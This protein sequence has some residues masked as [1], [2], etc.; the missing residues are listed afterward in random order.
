MMG[1]DRAMAEVCVKGS[2]SNADKAGDTKVRPVYMER[3]DGGDIEVS[4][5]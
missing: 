5:G 4:V 3:T 2:L 1:D